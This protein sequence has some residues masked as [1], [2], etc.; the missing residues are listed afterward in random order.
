MWAQKVKAHCFEEQKWAFIVGSGSVRSLRSVWT[1]WVNYNVGNMSLRMNGCFLL[2]LFG[3]SRSRV[4]PRETK[5]TWAVLMYIESL[6]QCCRQ[7][8]RRTIYVS[9]GR[10]SVS[11][12]V[13]SARKK[14][15]DGPNGLS[16]GRLLSS[17]G[18]HT[19]LKMKLGARTHQCSRKKTP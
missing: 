10:L 7:S 2:L 9:V 1:G 15:A 6:P 17:S 14:L 5:C 4:R 16:V 19:V 8:W 3:L 13:G 12:V 11:L 18:A